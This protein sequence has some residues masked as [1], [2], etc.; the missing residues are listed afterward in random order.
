MFANHSGGD[1][2]F[3]CFGD[4]ASDSVFGERDS[5]G[6]VEVLDLVAGAFQRSQPSVVDVC[7]REFGAGFYCKNSHLAENL[8]IYFDAQ[9]FDAAD[10][11]GSGVV[12]GGDST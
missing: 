12:P 11:E 5:V 9:I 2:S 6:Q 3:F 1:L 10:V 7:D 4:F 8:K